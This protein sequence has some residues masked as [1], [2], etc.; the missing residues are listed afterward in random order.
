MYVLG[1]KFYSRIRLELLFLVK[2]SFQ[3]VEVRQLMVNNKGYGFVFFIYINFLGMQ[4]FN[5]V[6]ILRLEDFWL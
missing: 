6:V 4:N 5:I 3:V 2:L 1:E